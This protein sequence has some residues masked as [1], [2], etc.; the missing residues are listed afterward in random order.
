MGATGLTANGSDIHHSRVGSTCLPPEF[1][2]I[3]RRGDPSFKRILIAHPSVDVWAYGKL[4]YEVLTGKELIEFNEEKEPRDDKDALYKL[5]RWN[6]DELRRILDDLLGVGVDPSGVEL[7]RLCLQPNRRDRPSM[8]D[9]LQH[10]FWFTLKRKSRPSRRS[11][12]SSILSVPTSASMFSA[13]PPD[14]GEI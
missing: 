11:M 1:I 13:D 3:D 14:L 5:A 8:A 2:Q 9:V 12:A 6:Q 10:E 7:V 4:L